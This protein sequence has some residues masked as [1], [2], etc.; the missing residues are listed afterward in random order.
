MRWYSRLL[1]VAASLL[2]AAAV[3]LP[4]ELPDQRN[5]PQPRGLTLW[6]ISLR[7]PQYPEGLGMIISASGLRGEGKHDIDS[8]NNLNHYIGMKLIHPDSILEVKTVPWALGFFTLFGLGIALTGSRKGAAWWCGL[9]MLYG[10]FIMWRFW[11]WEY[12]YGH[13]LDYE[14]APIKIPGMTYQPPLIGYKRLLNFEVWSYAAI[15]SWVCIA[16][17]AL[18]ALAYFL[19]ARER[20]AQG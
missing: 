10:A 7:A 1:M 18:A 9:L 5:Y 16:G 15:G 13:N 17:M 3:L 14:N 12:D 11:A 20:P 19:P 2:M 4:S 6:K 8:V